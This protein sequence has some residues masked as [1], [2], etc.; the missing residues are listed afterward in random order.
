M[1][2]MAELR[3]DEQTAL[4]TLET[5][6]TKRQE[7]ARLR[8]VVSGRYRELSACEADA[9]KVTQQV[10]Q[11]ESKLKAFNKQILRGAAKAGELPALKEQLAEAKERLAKLL[12][13]LDERREEFCMAQETLTQLRDEL[14]EQQKQLRDNLSRLF[15]QRFVED[16]V[17]LYGRRGQ[18]SWMDPDP[19]SPERYAKQ[20]RARVF[21]FLLFR[22]LSADLTE[23]HLL[24]ALVVFF[25][26]EPFQVRVISGFVPVSS[27]NKVPL[28]VGVLVSV[29]GGL[30]EA[31]GFEE[32]TRGRVR[33]LTES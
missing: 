9:Q 20:W 29:P 11:H 28:E 31:E 26:Q 16:D 1:T 24:H 17:G 19:N 13:A 3:V 21:N 33:F 2:A 22:G 10:D 23:S 32:I 5:H 4:S 6:I 30:S 7:A 15:D 12:L 27:R 25:R 8:E 18:V 14:Q